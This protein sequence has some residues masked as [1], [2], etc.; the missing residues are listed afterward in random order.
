M[1]FRLSLPLVSFVSMNL[2]PIFFQLLPRLSVC[3]ILVALFL[4]GSAKVQ[5]FSFLPN[6]PP[7]FFLFFLSICFNFLIF[8]DIQYDLFHIILSHYFSTLYIYPLWGVI[9]Y[10]LSLIIFIFLYIG[11]VFIC[12]DSLI[13]SIIYIYSPSL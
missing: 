6:I 13:Y 5:L 1:F 8:Q 10:L 2:S 3:S 12:L 4:I 7:L 9:I 11:I